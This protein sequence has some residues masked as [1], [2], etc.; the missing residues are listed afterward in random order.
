MK[1][2]MEAKEVNAGEATMAILN[3]FL[4]SVL[5]TVPDS[6]CISGWP[7]R[8]KLAQQDYE[9]TQFGWS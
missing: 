1:K 9:I 5:P 6:Y 3:L 8:L 7:A 2:E 4:S